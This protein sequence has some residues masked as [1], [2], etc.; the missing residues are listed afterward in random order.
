MLK[1]RL[2]LPSLFLLLSGVVLL[3]AALLGAEAQAQTE[4]RQAGQRDGALYL[5]PQAGGARVE[6]AGGHALDL[7]L[8]ERADL[9]A[10]AAVGE[11]WLAAGTRIDRQG[12]RQLLILTGDRGGFE[13]LAPPPGPRQAVRD[14]PV[15]LVTGGRLAGLA[16]LE[17]DDPRT[18]SVLAASWDGERWGEVE[19]VAAGGRAGEA[20][21]SQLALTGA[22]L[23]DGSWLLAW[24]RFDGEDDEIVWSARKAGRWSAQARV[25]ADNRVPDVLPALAAL[26][27]GAVLAWSRYDGNDYRL[28]LA[29][30]DGKAARDERVVGEAGS[31]D[32][33]FAA[34]GGG[35]FLLY[36]ATRPA[37]WSLLALDDAG[38][39]KAR[40]LVEGAERSRPVVVVEPDGTPRL[41]WPDSQQEA[42]VRL[43]QV[44]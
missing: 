36:K 37:G 21:G 19:R 24:S 42:A 18:L 35:P 4:A 27:N 3:G 23:A 31:L 33:T 30:L 20:G 40:G 29:R 32:A 7:T 9:Q 12:R 34:G 8:P 14:Q 5:V 15:P 25:S 6:L 39:I 41:R 1:R 38:Q 2:V 44:P 43:R 17:G 16:W 28:M 13:T 26:G 22:V 11:G 10:L